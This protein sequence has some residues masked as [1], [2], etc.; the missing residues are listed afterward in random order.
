VTTCFFRAEALGTAPDAAGAYEPGICNIG[1]MEIARR[2]MVGHVG[3]GATL[4]VLGILIA[5]D[6]PPPSRLAAAIP[7]MISASGYLQANLRFCA[8]YG[9]RGV[10]NFG[11]PDDAEAV[12]DEDARAADRRKARQ[13]SLWSLAIGL[14]VGVAG[15]IFPI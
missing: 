15:M 6:A 9:Q 5:V 10:F 12:V 4:A 8:G 11:E 13:I 2:R 7:A 14:A 3:L 1:P